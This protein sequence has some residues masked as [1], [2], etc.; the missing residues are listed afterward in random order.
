MENQTRLRGINKKIE[1]YSSNTKHIR[2]LVLKCFIGLLLLCSIPSLSGCVKAMIENPIKRH[3]A[4]DSPGTYSQ[5]KS[6]I[7]LIP[8]SSGRLFVYI[9]GKGS[10]GGP[11][12]VGDM[13]FCTVD[14]GIYRIMGDTFWH[15]D[16]QPGT[17]KITAEKVISQNFWTTR[18]T[19]RYG[20]NSVNFDLKEGESQYCRIIIGGFG[21][22]TTFKP[23]M[24]DQTTALQEIKNLDYYKKFE[25]KEPYKWEDN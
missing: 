2:F 23:I 7:P 4:K 6:S 15:L 25:F 13:S 16:L 21:K 19:A 8:A 17:H 11:F 18:L 10:P 14:Q 5:I 12:G 20:K 24:V 9:I 3:Y 1:K 22:W